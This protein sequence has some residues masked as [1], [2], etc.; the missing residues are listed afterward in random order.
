MSTS[1]A[2]Q[3]I[4]TIFFGITLPS[5]DV[6]SDIYLALR[7]FENGHPNFACCVLLPVLTNT[8]FTI[9]VC[10]HLEKTKCSMYFPLVL[11]QIYPQFCTAR[12]LYKWARG[13][14][15]IAEFK[16]QRDS[17]DG[18]LG[19]VEPYVESVPQAF[20]QTAIFTI[21]YNLTATATR[22]CYNENSRSCR[23]FDICSDLKKCSEIGHDN[24]N[25]DPVGFEPYSYK[26]SEE[27]AYCKNET[28]ICTTKFEDCIGPFYDCISNCT[29][30]L[31]EQIIKIDE[32]ELYESYTGGNT[33]W[34][35]DF[36][37][38]EYNAT[39]V[40]I[41][42][43]QLYLLFVGDKSTFMATYSISI[44]AAVYGA[45]KFSRLGYARHCDGID[46]WYIGSFLNT[47]CYIVLK[48][49]ALAMFVKNEENE[50]TEN[51]L[52]W[53]LFC[54]LPSFA[55]QFIVIIGTTGYR[56]CVPKSKKYKN[57]KKS[58]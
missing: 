51:I 11:L 26:S 53:L 37:A 4:I 6:G 33:N 54:V 50:M 21:A 7:L 16:S 39:L 29:A 36:L 34:T 40:D 28:Q 55:L 44:F 52:S 38:S 25:C 19:C 56:V 12:L 48:G 2:I 49:Y 42:S 17:L 23:Q 15:G 13:A 10:V 27:I 20:I 46:L 31:T 47:L 43:V 41:K 58:I 14:T 22:L 57:K 18:G 32:I 5:F 1:N 3:W 24:N 35:N 30:N 8:V 9:F 45:T